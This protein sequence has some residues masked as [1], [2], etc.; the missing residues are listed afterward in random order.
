[1][2]DTKQTDSRRVVTEVLGDSPQVS[3]VF[4]ADGSSLFGRS[5]FEA[6]NHPWFHV[7]LAF[8]R[9]HHHFTG[10]YFECTSG[11]FHNM[12]RSGWTG[13]HYTMAL[14]AWRNANRSYR[15]LAFRNL[16]LSPL[17]AT[18]CLRK[19][20]R[21][22]GHMRYAE[23]ALL[24]LAIANQSGV[25]IPAFGRTPHWCTCSEAVTLMLPS[26]LQHLL[27]VDT[28]HAPDDVY[29]S[30]GP[31]SNLWNLCNAIDRE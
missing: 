9:L 30:G 3:I 15:I 28:T 24:R 29:P 2:R 13:P 8:H 14:E 4:F 6:T 18:L 17:E 23:L 22:V 19:A 11:L 27:G 1:M 21:A 12:D 20:Y 26:R 31:G 10:Y 7:A 16:K 5:Y 25:K